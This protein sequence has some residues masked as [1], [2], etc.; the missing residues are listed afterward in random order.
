VTKSIHA[1]FMSIDA[2]ND[3]L[4]SQGRERTFKMLHLR[5]EGH[6]HKAKKSTDEKCMRISDERAQT[7]T[8]LVSASGVPR[9]FL[10]PQG[11]GASRPLGGADV[12][13]RVEI[14]VMTTQEL[15]DYIEVCATAHIIYVAPSRVRH[16][17][18]HI[19]DT[20]TQYTVRLYH[21]CSCTQYTVRLYHPF[22]PYTLP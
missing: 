9:R 8:Q 12:N 18:H 1:I 21:P 16:C 14:Y 10:H 7:V 17:P 19:C 6:V 20:C 5:I 15:Q 13:K 3:R 2:V 4:E 22:S 11:F